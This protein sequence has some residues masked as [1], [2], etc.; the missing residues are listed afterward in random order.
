MT[1]TITAHSIKT[2][3]ATAIVV[4]VIGQLLKSH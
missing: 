3:I 4:P 1:R 2:W